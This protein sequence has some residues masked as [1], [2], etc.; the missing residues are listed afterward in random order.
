MDSFHERYIKSM[1]QKR[2]IKVAIL[3]TGLD[4]ENSMILD[5]RK[6]R[7]SST[8]DREDKG[9]AGNSNHDPIVQTISFTAKPVLDTYGHGTQIASLLMRIAPSAEIFVAKIFDGGSVES[10]DNVVKVPRP[11]FPSP[12]SH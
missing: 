2:R 1:K 4:R 3:D 5:T 8:N 12:T 11:Q 6:R 10:A 9:E 7:M